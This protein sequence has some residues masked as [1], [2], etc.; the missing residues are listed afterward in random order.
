MKFPPPL[1][2]WIPIVVFCFVALVGIFASFYERQTEERNIEERARTRAHALGTKL[3]S[4]ASFLIEMNSISGVRREVSLTAALPNV[5]QIV[6]LNP[7]NVVAFASRQEQVELPLAKS[8]AAPFA[9][10][11]AQAHESGS[12]RVVLSG[13]RLQIVGAFPFP[14]VNARA[15]VKQKSNGVALLILDLSAEKD[16]AAAEVNRRLLIVGLIFLVLGF[17]LTLIFYRML[18]VRV[19]HLVNTAQQLATGDL[20]T[21]AALDGGDEIADLGR[22]FDEM[23]ARLEQRDAMLVETEQRFREMAN[24][25]EEAFWILDF[26]AGATRLVTP[27]FARIFGLKPANITKFN[28][29]WRDAIHPDDKAWVLAEFEKERT[30]RDELEYRIVRPDGSTRWLRDRCFPVRDKNGD[31][32]R[33]VGI[34]AD[35]TERRLAADEKATFDRKI[36]ET[37]RLESLGVLAGGIAHDFNNLLTGVLGYASLSKMSLSATDKVQTFLT[38]IEN[39]AVKAADLCKQMLAYSGRGKFVV[40]LLD[41]SALVHE[42]TQ[43]LQLSIAKNVVLRFNLANDLPPIKADP[44]QLSQ[45]VMNLVINASDALANKSGTISLTTC[46]VRVDADYLATTVLMEPLPPGDYV[47][48]EAADNGCGMSAETKSRIFEPFYTTK[49]T[50]RGLGLSAVL[51]IVRSHHGAMRVYS[52]V[53]KGT[54]FKLFFPIAEGHAAPLSASAAADSTFRGSGV[55]LV[56]DDEDTVRTVSARLL[57]AMGFNVILACDG[58]DALEK[59]KAHRSEI[60]AVLMDLTMPHMN[61]EEAFRQLRILDPELRV[62]LMSG[63]NEQEAVNRFTGKGLSGF[64]EKPFRA[65]ILRAKL[66]AAGL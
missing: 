11:L 9:P 24:N 39:T 2:I 20:T 18:T 41:L 43:L 22:A 44:T 35:I 34:V 40:Q 16:L 14:Y 49:F 19:R 64:I 26:K 51:G 63:F 48:L 23:A 13:D 56:V 53:G 38:E 29:Q 30:G 46:L 15:G 60:R 52:E 62:L 61:G 5:E 12:G 4:M 45:V 47:F 10:L 42:T 28:I 8:I 59:Y 25:I 17:L 57:E 37:Q 58:V 33:V 21:R 31:V 54:M 1:R 32:T 7:D 66:Q 65:E 6:V 36:Q 27:A 3:S 55:I 50:G